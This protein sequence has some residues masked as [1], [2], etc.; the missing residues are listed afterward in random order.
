MLGKEQCSINTYL[1]N[2]LPLTSHT[3]ASIKQKEKEV[4]L[5]Q[6]KAESKV[7]KMLKRKQY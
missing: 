1:Y 5:V 3:A 7:V 6:N 2:L 4:N